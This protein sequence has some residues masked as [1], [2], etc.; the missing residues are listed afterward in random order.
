MSLFQATRVLACRCRRRLS[1][2]ECDQ[3]MVDRPA[4]SSQLRR[5]PIPTHL[6]PIVAVVMYNVVSVD[7]Y[8]AC[9]LVLPVD[10]TA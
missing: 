4:V 9:N 7:G 8:I 5:R 1:L 6:V 3:R 10:A 2:R